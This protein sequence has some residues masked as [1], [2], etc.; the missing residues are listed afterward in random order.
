MVLL[1]HILQISKAIPVASQVM[2]ALCENGYVFFE[3][4]NEG[5]L[6]PAYNAKN[7]STLTVTLSY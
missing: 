3:R 1:N 6:S 7:F 2:D 5:E 4:T